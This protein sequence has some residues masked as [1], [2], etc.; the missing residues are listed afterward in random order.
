[1]DETVTV[2][3][4]KYAL[5]SGIIKCSGKICNQVFS[6]DN[7]RKFNVL[8]LD[9]FTSKE[10]VLTETEAQKV[11]EEKRLKAIKQTERKLEKLKNLKMQLNEY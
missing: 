9:G 5:T 11:F 1:M 10:Y 2:Y 8:M 4:T 3:I 6:P 7:P